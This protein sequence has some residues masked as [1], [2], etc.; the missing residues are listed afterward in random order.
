M[1]NR[2]KFDFITFIDE[3]ESGEFKN[4]ENMI[5]NGLATPDIE[6]ALI[7]EANFVLNGK[8]TP[9]EQLFIAEH[10]ERTFHQSNINNFSTKHFI[11]KTKFILREDKFLLITEQFLLKNFCQATETTETSTLMNFVKQCVNLNLN[12]FIKDIAKNPSLYNLKSVDN[13][14]K[15]IAFTKKTTFD[16]EIFV[17][18]C[19]KNDFNFIQ[20]LMN[21]QF[22]MDVK[23]KYVKF[24]FNNT[25]SNQEHYELAKF[26]NKCFPESKI[27]KLEITH[28][29][30]LHELYN[31]PLPM[32]EN[33]DNSII[34]KE[35][36]D[37]SSVRPFQNFIGKLLSNNSELDCAPQ[38]LSRVIDYVKSYNKDFYLG[39]T[40]FKNICTFSPYSVVELI[41]EKGIGLTPTNPNEGMIGIPPFKLN[42]KFSSTQQKYLAEYICKNF[43]VDGDI[44]DFLSSY[45]ENDS[46]GTIGDNIENDSSDVIGDNNVNNTD[47]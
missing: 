47:N 45:S 9:E 30:K 5:V 44:N 1:K 36:I 8:F 16:H 34:N 21:N 32:I 11:L 17:D 29:I 43:F 25:F 10:I 37:Y 42:D 18:A 20:V 2:D 46:I 40:I 35:E 23:N 15:M 7:T 28:V 13:A 27:D 22:A 24:I 31:N 39:Y 4:V 3:C 14:I 12:D 41:L 19:A 26:I 6:D 33:E 38:K